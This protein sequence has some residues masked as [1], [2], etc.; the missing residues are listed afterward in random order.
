MRPVPIV[1][2]PVFVDDALQPAQAQDD[3]VIQALLMETPDP[4][5]GKSIGVGRCVRRV[6]GIN[7]RASQHRI[8]TIRIASVVVTEK[9]PC[10]NALLLTGPENGAGLLFQP[11]A[12]G[13]ERCPRHK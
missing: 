12:I 6:N 10:V 4:T 1:E 13:R 8:E 3:R 11:W 9:E 2:S 7:T 5:L